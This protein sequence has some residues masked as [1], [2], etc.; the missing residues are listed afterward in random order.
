MIDTAHGGIKCIHPN[1]TNRCQKHT[2]YLKWIRIGTPVT[3]TIPY[4]YWLRP[5]SAIIANLPY[6]QR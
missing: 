1:T 5:K 4:E 3:I 2:Q 6:T